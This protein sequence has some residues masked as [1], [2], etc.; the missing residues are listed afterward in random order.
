MLTKIGSYDGV[1]KTLQSMYPQ[2]VVSQPLPV[3]KPIG[4]GP[5]IV[6][7]VPHPNP[8]ELQSSLSEQ[9]RAL[10]EYDDKLKAFAAEL[11]ATRAALQ[12]REMA[13]IMKE[14][15]LEE[16][17]KSKITNI[18]QP[19]SQLPTPPG[20]SLQSNNNGNKLP[21]PVP[22]PSKP[23]QPP[24]AN[25]VN[26]ATPRSNTAPP[27]IFPTGLPEFPFDLGKLPA[28]FN[29]AGIT[30]I[31]KRFSCGYSMCSRVVLAKDDPLSMCARCKNFFC[32]EH[33]GVLTITI[34]T[35]CIR[36]QIVQPFAT[37]L[38][39]SEVSKQLPGQARDMS[40]RFK[41]IRSVGHQAREAECNQW[42]EKVTPSLCMLS[43]LQEPSI[44]GSI[45]KLNPFKN[46]VF[47]KDTTSDCGQCRTH[48]D[49]L[50]VKYPCELCG[51]VLCIRC[52]STLFPLDPLW[53]ASAFI[54]EREGVGV[55]RVTLCQECA[56]RVKYYEHK[57]EVERW[58]TE[59]PKLP[60]LGKYAEFVHMKQ[61]IESEL[62]ILVEM[63]Q[64][65]DASPVNVDDE[66][67]KA[68]VNLQTSLKESFVKYYTMFSWIS[69]Q[70]KEA[71]GNAS[72]LSMYSL[73]KNWAAS[74]INEKKAV[75][76]RCQNILQKVASNNTQPSKS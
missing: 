20:A 10:R 61:S 13:L 26:A 42:I 33:V 34:P 59:A 76:L 71:A 23:M 24:I 53:I 72:A 5:P 1:L 6:S 44:P 48:F 54:S 29:F 49:L 45:G 63:C 37:C 67:L 8:A 14:K 3:N 2:Q 56:Y 52:G 40:K 47:R 9:W 75:F 32:P 55:L 38:Q 30:G 16:F 18:Q 60:I 27:A 46:V 51:C 11:E 31:S 64:R 41:E 4:A 25:Q 39:C 43:N 62:C 65:L 12:Q 57:R 36:G 69:A 74:D 70:H 68:I 17:M 35:T 7:V 73:L 50:D 28:L 19:L 21:Q 22:S 15:Q 58:S 66:Q